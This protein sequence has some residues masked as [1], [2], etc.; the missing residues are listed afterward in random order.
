M[1]RNDMVIAGA[2]LFSLPT[3]SPQTLC[4]SHAAD[5]GHWRLSRPGHASAGRNV[6]CCPHCGG[7]ISSI[8]GPEQMVQDVPS[9]LGVPHKPRTVIIDGDRLTLEKVLVV[10]LHG[11]EV[12]LSRA[13]SFAS[14]IE[15]GAKVLHDALASG[16]E[17]YGVTTGYGDNCTTAIPPDLVAELP[18]N[19]IRYHGVGT[20]RILSD[21]ACRAV[22]LC[23]LNSLA[24]GYSGVTL[25]LLRQLE[26][27][28]NHRIHPCIPE[29]GSV[30]A[31]GDLTPL[32]YLAAAMTGRRMVRYS[33]KVVPAAQALRKAGLKPLRLE[34]K[35]GLALMNGTA[36]MTGLACLAFGRASQLGRLSCRLTAAA[37]HALGGDPAHFDVVLF[38]VKPHAGQQEAAR[39]IRADLG[40]ARKAAAGRIQDRY[41][42]RCAPHV[43]GVLMDALS[44]IRRDLENEL[45]SA[46]DNPIV[47]PV[48]G[49]ILHGGHFYGGH[50]AFAMDSL[51]AA[52]ASVA[53]LLDRQLALLVDPRFNNGLPG[54][55]SGA[56]GRRAVLQHG[57]KAVQIAASSWTAEALRLTMPAA[58]FSRSTESHNQDKVSMGTISA[59]DALRVLEL[60]EQVAA[61]SVLASSQALQLRANL[62]GESSPP[63]ALAAFAQT[64]RARYGILDS[65]R[66]LD[67]DLTACAEAVRTGLW[68][69]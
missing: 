5:G 11:A 24:M 10:A 55:L 25:R 8:N 36:V 58:S 7:L 44:W 53:D 68:A 64:V 15:R 29:E 40:K 56:S 27:M 43:I 42:I 67:V 62:E 30:G 12:R 59:R 41:S 35:E 69:A 13:P 9:N 52:V 54:G 61:A 45:N 48:S 37:S 46:N 1:M 47:D 60:A 21:E 16:Q 26:A 65:D 38:S 50:V 14:R 57:F 4:F 3:W 20:G 17:I 23:R 2:R 34:P 18:D 33:G 31:S 32:S 51:K 49:R 19:L 6:V 39:R 66:E 63:P 22:M 28:L